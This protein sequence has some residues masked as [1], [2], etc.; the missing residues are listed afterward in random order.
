M[1]KQPRDDG[2]EAIPV[3]GLRPGGGKQIV[4]SGASTRSTAIS[5]SVRVVTLYATQDCFVETGDATVEANG[6]TS[7]FLP[8]SIPYDISLGAETVASE[9][10]RYVSV[11]A[12]S[13][14]GTLY[15]S[16]RE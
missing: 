4:F 15:L 7:H 9:N 3:L 8:A 2:N 13:D 10:D 16:E 11:I 5:N 14:S 1:S 6:S 12:V